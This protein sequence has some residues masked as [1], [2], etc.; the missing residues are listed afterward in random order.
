MKT[1]FRNRAFLPVLIPVVLL[2][3]MA[4]FIGLFALILLYNTHEGALM[5]A[6]VA[7]AG[8]LF[9]VSLANA[10]DRLD[11][12]RRV[13][14][15]AAAALPFLIGGAFAAGWIGD[16]PDEARNVNEQPEIQVP[17]DAIIAAENSQEFCLPQNGD[18]EP[19][20]TW[21]VA[22]QGE[23]EPFT[24]AFENREA[25]IPHNVEIFTLAGDASDPEQGDLIFDG[26]EPFAGVATRVGEL[27]EPLAVGEYY[28]HCLVHQN[29]NGVLEIVEGE[30]DEA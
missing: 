14:V 12:G 30:G 9:T 7:A 26:Q 28:F 10:R 18:C 25:G 4:L 8:I 17:E 21:T 19:A 16:I 20:D 23:E 15:V 11:P 2:L 27:E 3:A 24:F 22:F 13:V 6:V 29:M 5:L 1:E